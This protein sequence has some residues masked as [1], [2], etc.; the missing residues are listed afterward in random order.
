MSDKQAYSVPV[1]DPDTG[2]GWDERVYAESPT[3]AIQ[4]LPDDVFVASPFIEKH[5]LR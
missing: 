4:K 2:D 1:I 5:D 3:A